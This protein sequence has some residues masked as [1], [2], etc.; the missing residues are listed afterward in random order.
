[1]IK[2][3]T[4]KKR[5]LTITHNVKINVQNYIMKFINTIFV[6]TSINVS[7]FVSC[8]VFAQQGLIQKNKLKD[9]H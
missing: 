5:D 3:V 4:L 1:M 7:R 2:F 8:K 6:R 9:K